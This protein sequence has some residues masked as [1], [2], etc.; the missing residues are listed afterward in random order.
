MIDWACPIDNLSS[1]R[2]EQSASN[3]VCNQTSSGGFVDPDQPCAD[4]SV[5]VSRSRLR[6]NPVRAV[7]IVKP[8]VGYDECERIPLLQIG[9]GRT[10]R[11]ARKEPE[12]QAQ[13]PFAHQVEGLLRE[14]QSGRRDLNPRPHRPDLS[15]RSGISPRSSRNAKL[16]G[17]AT[18]TP[19]MGSRRLSGLIDKAER[20]PAALAS[21]IGGGSGIGRDFGGDAGELQ[22]V[23]TQ[24]CSDQP[25]LKLFLMRCLR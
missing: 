5:T 10:R 25:R 16:L 13:K 9:V 24:S 1:L 22:H 8:E 17:A 18:P 23:L 15:G 20:S 19:T 4:P 3:P 2:Q 11:D 21:K 6:F 14:S 7:E 12:N